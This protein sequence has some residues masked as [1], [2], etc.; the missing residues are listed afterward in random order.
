MQPDLAQIPAW[1][2]HYFLRKKR[3]VER[4]GDSRVTYAVFMRRPVIAAPRLAVGWLKEV[5]AARGAAVEI[6]VN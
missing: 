5:A 1:T 6:E 4:F 3:A 2:D